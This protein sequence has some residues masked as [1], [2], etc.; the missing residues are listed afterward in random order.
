ASSGVGIAAVQIAKLFGC[1]VI[2][3]AGGRA[4]LEMARALGADAVTDHYDAARPV[5]RAV[6]EFAP[7]G[8]DVV[9][10]HVGQASW[11]QSLRALAPNGVL[12]TCGATTGHEA[13][14]D[15][16]F[17]FS[18]QLRL[19]GSYMGRRADLDVIVPL[20]SQGKLRGS[21]PGVSAGGR[22]RRACAPGRGA[23]IREG[24][25]GD[26]LGG[27]RLVA[28]LKAAIERCKYCWLVLW[29]EGE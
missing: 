9:V 18:R 10:E 2:A 17:L 7:E 26:W 6:K 12:V 20:I 23:A 19:L 1:R 14:L 8:V 11:E 13:K 29:N 25:A 22:G 24:G 21:G 28:A 5:A 15:L 16:R 27:Q 3:T 4:K